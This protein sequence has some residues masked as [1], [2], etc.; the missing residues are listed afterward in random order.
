MIENICVNDLVKTKSGMYIEVLVQPNNNSTTYIAGKNINTGET[1]VFKRSDIDVVRSS[2]LQ[3]YVSEPPYYYIFKDN[4]IQTRELVANWAKFLE[5]FKDIP[6]SDII[7]NHMYTCDLANEYSANVYSC[8]SVILY[9]N[10]LAL[11]ADM[12][13]DAKR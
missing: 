12:Q 11:P 5:E 4:G 9:S 1:A 6:V 13:V 8:N 2:T 7:L 3:P 10:I